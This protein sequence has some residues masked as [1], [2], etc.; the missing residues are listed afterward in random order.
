M[1]AA[2][3]DST[4]SHSGIFACGAAR[5]TT[6]I[7][8]GARVSRLRSKSICSAFASGYLAAKAAAIAA[9]ALSRAGPAKTMNRHGVSLPWSGTR[10]AIVSSVSSSDGDG[11]GSTSSTGLSERRLRN[12]V[13]RMR[14]GWHLHDWHSRTLA[15]TLQPW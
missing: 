12:K 9:P 4:C 14:K 3:D 15:I 5:L 8:R 10:D 6:A 7:T 1:A 2:P 11:P 13:D